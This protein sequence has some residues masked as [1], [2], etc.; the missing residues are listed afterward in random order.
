MSVVRDEAVI[1][2]DVEC[3]AYDTDLALWREL[4]DVAAGPVLEIGCG[5]GRVALDLA[6]EG[7]AVIAVDIDAALVEALRERARARGLDLG[8]RVGDARALDPD[9]TFALIVVPMQT[10][11]LLGGSDERRAALAAAARSLR[12]G[13]LLAIAI[14][15]G[16]PAGAGEP[17]QPL[18]DVVEID[19][20]IYSSLPLEIVDEGD[21][22]LVTR[23]RQ[24]V[25]PVGDLS[26]AMD[27]TR[28]AVLD[29]V[30][31]EREGQE[32]G[33]RPAGRR[34]VPTT[35]DHVG[36]VVVLLERR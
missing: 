1:W 27:E 10:L 28:L 21:S 15:E 12:P 11:Q 24:V 35:T 25:S 32:A 17:T 23:L 4:A 18:P 14:V 16:I 9:E 2:H 29:A 22:L 36:S 30:T 31:I 33:L 34:E 20:W 5:T 13:G 26:E 8:A 7:H 3:G 6:R 19:G